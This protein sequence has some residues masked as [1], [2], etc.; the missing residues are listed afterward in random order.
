MVIF[1]SYVSLPEGTWLF[2]TEDIEVRAF[3]CE[4]LWTSLDQVCSLAPLLQKIL[5]N[6]RWDARWGAAPAAAAAC[7]ATIAMEVAA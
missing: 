1:H 7:T 5:S 6:C 2:H 3:E 4:Q